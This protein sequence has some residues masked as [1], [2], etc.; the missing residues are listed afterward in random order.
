M[1][2]VSLTKTDERCHFSFQWVDNEDSVDINLL[3]SVEGTSVKQDE[4]I[5]KEEAESFH[6][7]FGIR[8]Y[9][10]RSIRALMSKCEDAIVLLK[11]K[12]ELMVLL[13]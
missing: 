8:F 1:Y 11:N 12:K 2:G 13:S 9:D 5:P 4:F 6:P 7:V 10:E 3:Y